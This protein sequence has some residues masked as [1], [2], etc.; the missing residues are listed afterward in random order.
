MAEFARCPF[1]KTTA[2]CS[3]SFCHF[4]L[5]SSVSRSQRPLIFINSYQS[6]ETSRTSSNL[7]ATPL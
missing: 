1:A 7:S 2:N 4:D 3:N 5:I 6:P